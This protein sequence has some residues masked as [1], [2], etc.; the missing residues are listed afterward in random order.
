MAYDTK[1]LQNPSGS[2]TWTSSQLTGVYAATN[3]PAGMM[4][5]TSDLGLM[6]SN[7]TTWS[8]Q[9]PAPQY[10]TRL[11]IGLGALHGANATLKYAAYTKLLLFNINTFVDTLGTSTFSSTLSA[12]TV[13]LTVIT[14]TNTTGTAITLTTATFGPFVVG[15]IA[16][17]TST[18]TA[19][20]GGFNQFALN[21][22]AG[23]VVPSG[24]ELVITGGTDATNTT[25]VT[26]DYQLST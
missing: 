19:M 22:T 8:A 4:A 1:V 9:T 25:I 16:L 21:S 15:G 20:A 6:V 7:G 2:G 5:Y 13:Q 3:Y 26:L 23:Y 17:S 18:G 12:N 24:S 14:N 10:L 11:S